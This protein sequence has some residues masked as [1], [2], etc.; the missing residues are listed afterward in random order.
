MCRWED[1][2]VEASVYV[3]QLPSRRVDKDALM[4]AVMIDRQWQHEL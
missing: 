3:N 1:D 4:K 2:A